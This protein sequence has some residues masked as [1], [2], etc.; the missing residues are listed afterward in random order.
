MT[1]I[2]GQRE[3]CYNSLTSVQV[4]NLNSFNCSIGH[5][6]ALSAK[7]NES[8]NQLSHFEG[9][10]IITCSQMRSIKVC[11]AFDRIVHNF[12]FKEKSCIKRR[13]L[14]GYTMAS[15]RYT[16]YTT[17]RFTNQKGY[18]HTGTSSSQCIHETLCQTFMH[19]LFTCSFWPLMHICN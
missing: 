11:W 18:T 5:Q 12:L 2:V 19:N 17:H 10:V 16:W 8:C 15:G 6:V 1:W 13:L 4:Q 3:H 7:T 14:S 9:C